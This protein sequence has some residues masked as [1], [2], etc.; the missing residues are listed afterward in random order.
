MA[1]R[2]RDQMEPG[3]SM[4]V[5]GSAATAVLTLTGMHCGSC[6]ALIE[7]T[8]AECHGVTGAVVDLTRATASVTFD[9]S[10]IG[11]ED[12]CTAVTR[13]GYGA[14]PQDSPTP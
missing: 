5:P 7:E 9:P 1:I 13:E 2:K 6:A 3:K 8:L 14:T 11:V 10:T 4:A 12:L